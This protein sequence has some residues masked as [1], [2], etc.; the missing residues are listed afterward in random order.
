[1][2]T[3]CIFAE[4]SSCSNCSRTFARL[5]FSLHVSS[6]QLRNAFSWRICVCV[7]FS[8]SVSVSVMVSGS[9]AVWLWLCACQCVSDSDSDSVGGGV[10][11][12]GV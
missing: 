5:S 12:T 10:G 1:M 6:S 4:P 3:C 7:S 11:G 8:V 2:H 9:V